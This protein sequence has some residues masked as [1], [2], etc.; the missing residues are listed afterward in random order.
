M[1]LISAEDLAAR[2]DDWDNEQRR[3]VAI[4]G[5]QGSGKS[6]FAEKLD[7]ERNAR[8]AGECRHPGDGRI[9]SRRHGARTPWIGSRK[10]VAETVDVAGF[11]HMIGRLRDN[12]EPEIAAPVF[13]R[14]IEIARAGA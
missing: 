4:V 6:T 8:S 3:I 1:Q 9:S 7:A 10:G 12:L 11:M 13:D 14:R 5:P 2:I